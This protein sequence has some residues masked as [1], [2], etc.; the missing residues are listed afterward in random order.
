MEI[1]SHESDDCSRRANGVL[2]LMDRFSVFFG[3]KLSIL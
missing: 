3:I 2:A 1:S